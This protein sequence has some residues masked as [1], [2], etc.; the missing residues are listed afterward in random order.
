MARSAEAAS[1]PQV[2][3]VWYPDW[4]KENVPDQKGRVAIVTGSNSGTGFWCA[5][6]LAG[7]GARV[8]LACRTP[9]KAEAAKEEILQTHPHAQV[10]VFRLDNMDL[11]SVRDF[12]AAFKSKYGRLDLLINNAG[13][14]AQPLVDSKDGFDVQFQ[15]N[16]LAHFLL[17]SLLWDML[18]QTGGAR[19]VQHSSG[20]HAMGSFSR[21]DMEN[22][23]VTC[24]WSCALHCL[25]PCMGYPKG[26]W[27]RYGMSKLCNILFGMELQR[28]IDAAGLNDR[29]IS[30]FAHPGFASTQLQ[31]VAG[32]AMKGWERMNQKNA[33]SA[34]DGSLPLLMACVGRIN[35]GT[36][37]GPDTGMKGPPKIEQP[38]GHSKNET[39]AKDLWA[40]SE[41]CCNIKFD[42]PASAN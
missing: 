4:V 2:P 24:K 17:T 8:V 36:Y 18:V 14:M 34:A 15:S 20:A 6:A 28:K 42:I 11:S 37:V 30:T 12:A 35:G 19:V 16:H 23:P 31:S 27:R 40:Y 33:Q 21:H 22:P 3:V 1:V 39:M 32:D 7:K 13:I 25:M 41:E 5:S 26:P 29:V 9:V 10:E 38:V